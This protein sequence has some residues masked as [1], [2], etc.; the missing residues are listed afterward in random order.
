MKYLNHIPKNL[1]LVVNGCKV[2][3]VD[4]RTSDIYPYIKW[5]DVGVDPQGYAIKRS[6]THNLPEYVEGVFH[7]VQN[8]VINA[9][10]SR[11]DLINWSTAGEY[12]R[13]LENGVVTPYT[14]FNDGGVVSVAKLDIGQVSADVVGLITPVPVLKKETPTLSDMIAQIIEQ[15]GE[16]VEI[17]NSPVTINLV[18]YSRDGKT[19]GKTL[20]NYI[21][22][23]DR[24][25]FKK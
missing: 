11:K 21:H 23:L 13:I 24:G 7:I 2:G 6:V 18:V 9:N 5:V 10:R 1:A 4:G 14:G 16:V 3:T 8:D 20:A 17:R 12:D 22:P 15:G 25:L 19:Y